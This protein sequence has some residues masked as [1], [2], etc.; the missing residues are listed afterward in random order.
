MNRSEELDTEDA[1]SRA[2]C[3]FWRAVTY[4]K[5]NQPEAVQA[6]LERASTA[7]LD[8]AEHNQRWRIQGILN[9]FSGNEA[10]AKAAYQKVLDDDKRASKLFSPR[11]YLLQLTRLFPER[12][13]FQTMYHWFESQVH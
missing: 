7:M 3:A 1:I 13:S 8:V 10:A 6:E 4:T 11:L 5:L 9:L 2:Y 12:E